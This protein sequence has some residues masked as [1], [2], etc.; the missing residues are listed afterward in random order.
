MKGRNYQ[1]SDTVSADTQ[2]YLKTL[3]VLYVEDE[4]DTRILVKEYLNRFTG[5]LIVA[6]NGEEG[7]HAYLKYSP[8][9]IITDIQMPK[10]DGL[11]MVR[12]MRANGTNVPVIILTAFD[13]VDYLMNSINIGINKYVVKPINGSMLHDALL[14][15]TK[16]IMDEDQ[17]NSLRRKQISQLIDAERSLNGSVEKFIDVFE[18]APVIMTISSINNGRCLKANKRF[19]EVSGFCSEE[20][21]GKNLVDAGW[22]TQVDFM[23]LAE[24]D[25]TN[26]PIS[27]L[28]LTCQTKK[29][30]QRRLSYTSHTILLNGKECLLS[31]ALDIADQQRNGQKT[32]ISQ[33]LESVGRL[34]GGVAHDFNNKLTVIMGYAELAK[35]KITDTRCIEDCLKEVIKAAEYSRGIAAQLS[36]VS[37]HQVISSR[38][39]DVNVL[40]SNAQKTLRPFLKKDVHTIFLPC[41]DLWPVKID[42]VQIDQILMNLLLNAND[43]LPG[44]GTLEIETAN[45]AIPETGPE[46]SRYSPGD[47]VRV[48]VNDNGVGIDSKILAHVFESYFTTKGIGKGSGLGLSIVKDIVS[49]NGGF[50]D[51]ESQLGVGTTF[52]VFL[53]RSMP[54]NRMREQPEIRESKGSGSIVLVEDDE[55]V[56]EM[57]STALELSGYSVSKCL[58]PFEAISLCEQAGLKPNLIVADVVMPDMNGKELL[59]RI[60][61]FHAEVKI[62]FKS[63]Y[64]S[65]L[66]GVPETGGYMNT[67]IQKPVDISELYKKIHAIMNT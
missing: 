43:A 38:V 47:Y 20:I 30:D 27:N 42:P 11:A 54:A 2:R 36:A 25:A 53:P 17:A 59:E 40:V 34:A 26:G 41:K 39:V 33:R 66:R 35:K 50:I 48:T 22:F 58:T 29:G 19:L 28:E 23:Q 24:I 18:H 55:K 65:E 14:E 1:S 52:T 8:D 67:I 61:T 46:L 10:M 45:C 63:G 62:L 60:R 64:A 32:V 12:E 21:I 44:G 56:L 31:I 13:Q 3:S 7:L 9:I 37:K 16:K 51:V 15:C 49:R 4:K 57:T 5:D 6:A